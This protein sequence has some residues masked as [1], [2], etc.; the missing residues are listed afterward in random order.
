MNECWSI[1]DCSTDIV[2]TSCCHHNRVGEGWGGEGK[3]GG[4]CIGCMDEVVKDGWMN[5]WMGRWID[6]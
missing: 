2:N 1:S 4:W 6:G 3:T 5:E